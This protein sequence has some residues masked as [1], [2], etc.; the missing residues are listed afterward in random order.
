[1][2]LY[3]RMISSVYDLGVTSSKNTTKYCTSSGEHAFG[4]ST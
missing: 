3:V 2:Q 4:V 1:M